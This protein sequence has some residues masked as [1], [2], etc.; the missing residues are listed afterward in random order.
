MAGGRSLDQPT[1]VALSRPIGLRQADL[2]PWGIC[3]S[4]ALVVV[5]TYRR[6]S[7]M[8][9]VVA[10]VR[11]RRVLQGLGHPLVTVAVGLFFMAAV[12]IVV[13]AAQ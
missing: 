2:P 12:L 4:S 10:S 7:D 5:D 1:W 8:S 13:T 3:A 9:A 6:A 11:M